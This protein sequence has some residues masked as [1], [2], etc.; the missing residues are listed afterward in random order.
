MHISLA[1]GDVFGLHRSLL[2]DFA[3][4]IEARKLL[5][6]TY[7]DAQANYIELSD[8]SN[9]AENE[10]RQLMNMYGREKRLALL[11]FSFICFVL[12]D[13]NCSTC[14]A[15]HNP[16]PV[17]YFDVQHTGD[18][19]AAI[20]RQGDQTRGF[21]VPAKKRAMYSRSVAGQI[22]FSMHASTFYMAQLHVVYCMLNAA[23]CMLLLLL[24]VLVSQDVCADKKQKWNDASRMNESDGTPSALLASD[25]EVMFA[26]LSPQPCRIPR[27]PC[28][29]AAWI[30]THAAWC[31]SR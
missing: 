12:V 29:H 14:R 27:L 10:F 8:N 11:S 9:D 16:N 20:S 3:Q 30:Q 17:M 2:V 31:Q 21:S 22:G 7:P 1:S 26:P 28:M 25:L 13:F 19:A 15:G 18:V 24:P 6:D 5:L 4:N 23:C